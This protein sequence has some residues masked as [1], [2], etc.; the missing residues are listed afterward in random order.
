[1]DG[2]ESLREQGRR[3]TPQRRMIYAALLEQPGHATADELC[4]SIARTLPGVQRTTVYRTLDLLVE[5]GLVRRVMLGRAT[6]YEAVRAGTESHQHLVCDRC[7]RTFDVS[8]PEVPVWVESAALPHG[9][10]LARVELLGHGTCASC[11][12]LP[13]LDR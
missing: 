9:F 5:M 4:A 8:A 12:R 1:M 6:S 7:G 11:A 3:L 10:R 13:R 2:L